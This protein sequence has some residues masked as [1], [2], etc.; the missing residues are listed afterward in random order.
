MVGC[1]L[2]R[3]ITSLW[4][5]R[6]IRGVGFTS[7]QTLVPQYPVDVIENYERWR[8]TWSIE[9]LVDEA[10][11]VILPHDLRALLHPVECIA[12]T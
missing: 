12:V 4:F 1:R 6:T 8:Q 10:V 5:T 3:P 7:T 2:T 9:E 11:P